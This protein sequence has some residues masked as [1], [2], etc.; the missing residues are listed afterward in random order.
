M[1]LDHESGNTAGP[2]PLSQQWSEIVPSIGYFGQRRTSDDGLT[3]PV[4]AST[5]G[6]LEAPRLMVLLQHPQDQRV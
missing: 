6:R 1:K 5:E 4:M 2:L 3:L